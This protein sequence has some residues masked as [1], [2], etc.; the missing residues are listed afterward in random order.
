MD[1]EDLS[2]IFT[3]RSRTSEELTA[4]FQAQVR[5]LGDSPVELADRLQKLGDNRPYSTT[6]RGIQRMLTGETRVSG[7]MKALVTMMLRQQRRLKKKYADIVW[8]RLPDGSYASEVE[9]FG[10]TL[11]PQSRGRWLVHLRHKDGYSPPWPRWQDNLEAAKRKALVCVED[12]T[13]FLA[14]LEIERAAENHQN[15]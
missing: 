13:E 3:A 4:E 1:K 7:E 9:D 6:L 8:K 11:A 5:E 10:V 12:A 15:A 14:E 2:E